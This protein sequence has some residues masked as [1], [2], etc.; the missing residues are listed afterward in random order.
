VIA[1]AVGNEQSLVV[2]KTREPTFTPHQRPEPTTPEQGGADQ[3]PELI[4][5]L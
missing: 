4:D 5:T 3:T 1:R 2:R